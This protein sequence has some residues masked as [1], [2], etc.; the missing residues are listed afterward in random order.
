MK[1]MFTT[2]IASILLTACATTETKE[3][4]NV[5]E[6]SN[7]IVFTGFSSSE[8][9]TMTQTMRGFVC[10]PK[11]NAMELKNAELLS[12][13]GSDA[14]CNYNDS[15]SEIYTTY[16]S[17]FPNTGLEE[18]FQS[19]FFSTN[20]AMEKNGL[21][22]DEELSGTCQISILSKILMAT[23]EDNKDDKAI[24]ITP[25]PAAVFTGPGNKLSILTIHETDEHEFL[26]YRYSLPGS[27]KDDTEAACEFLNAQ[28]KFHK[29]YINE[30]K[31]IESTSDEGQLSQLLEA[32]KASEE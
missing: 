2:L 13:D 18:Y 29:K 19:S 10:P 20:L 8:D 22:H 15:E 16:L 6:K 5:A 23:K 17:K 30:A 25:I 12:P 31:G 3:N 21:T 4:S 11:V 7:A 1:N 32:L 26:K 27:S 24:V 14:F 9:G 28:S